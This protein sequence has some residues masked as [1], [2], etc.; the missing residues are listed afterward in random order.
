MPDLLIATDSPALFAEVCAA[1]EEPGTAIRWA[2]SGRAVLPALQQ[3]IADLVIT[4][5]QIGS[6][7]GLAVAMQATLEAAAGRLEK[8][9]PMLRAARPAGRHVPGQADGGSRLA[10]QAPRPA[11]DKRRRYGVAGRWEVLRPDAGARGAGRAAGVR[12]AG[13]PK[14][15]RPVKAAGGRAEGAGGVVLDGW[16]PMGALCAAVDGPLWGQDRHFEAS[17]SSAVQKCTRRG[18]WRGRGV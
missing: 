7:G 3:R 13:G 5:L 1:V 4:D 12:P 18:C 8:P 9:V 6:M 11:A 16:A 15:H 14:G 17:A 2:R 10:R